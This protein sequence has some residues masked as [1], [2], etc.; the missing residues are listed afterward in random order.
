[1]LRQAE[2]SQAH[3]QAATR[4]RPDQG[5]PEA[6]ARVAGPEFALQGLAVAAGAGTAAGQAARLHDRRLPDAQR[7]A[8]AS[9]IGR[10]QG[11]RH[12]QRVIACAQGAPG[13]EQPSQAQASGQVGLRRATALEPASDQTPFE[14]PAGG[15]SP[16]PREHRDA[17]EHAFDH[18]LEHVRI[19]ADAAADRAARRIEADAFTLGADVYFR[20]GTYSPGTAQGDRLIGHELTHV[21]QNDHGRVPGTASGAVEVSEPTDDLEKEAYA[22]EDSIAQRAA[23]FRSSRDATAADPAVHRAPVTSRSVIQRTCAACAAGDESEQRSPCRQC[24]AQALRAASG[25]TALRAR[26]T[27]RVQRWPSAEEVVGS[28]EGTLDDAGDAAAGA[29]QAAGETVE[30]ALDEAQVAVGEAATAVGETATAVGEAATAA[31]E[32]VYEAGGQAVDAVTQFG[33]W[34]ASEAGEAVR[35]LAQSL[36]GI[37]SITSAG[38]EITAPRVCPLDA[39]SYSF[40]MAPIEQEFMVPIVALPIG[41]LIAT[42]EVGLAGRLQPL[43]E[44]QAGPFCLE[45]IRIVIDPLG[46]TYG[47]SGGVSATVAASLGAM[48][49]GGLRGALG[50]HGVV[51]IGGVPVPIDIP[52]AGLEGGPAGLVRGI[53]AATLRVSEGLSISSGTISMSDSRQLDLGLAGDL[54][55]GAY[56]QLDILGA[57]VCRLHWQPLEWHG[58]IAGSLGISMGVA[59]VPGRP[60]AIL[61]TVSPPTFTGIPFDQIPLVLE[62]EGFS[63]DCPIKDRLCEV[64]DALHLLPSQNG[65]TWDWGGSYGPGPRLGGPLEVYQKMPGIPSSA[66]CRGAC[67]PDCDT[68]KTTPTHRHADPATGEVW[69]YTNF[70]D[71]NTNAGCRE[72]DAA[73]DWAAATH[74]ETGSGAIIMPWHMAANIE[75]TCNNLAGNCIAWIAGLPPYDGK[76]YFADA[77]ALVS[78]GAIPDAS[79]DCRADY[80]NAPDCTASHPDR[81]A[82]LAQWGLPKGLT[83]FRDCRIVQDWAAGSMIGCDGAPGNIWH[84]L[85]TDLGSGQDVT[86]SLYECICCSGDDTSSS[87]WREPQV[88]VEAGM[89]EELI[90]DLCERGLIPR[91]ICIPLEEDMIGR[92]GD[93]RRDLDLDPDED[94]QAHLRPDDAPILDSFRRMYN[95]LDSWNVFVRTNHPG[96]YPEFESRFHVEQNRERWINGPDGIKARTKRYKEEFRDLRNTDPERSRREY[97]EY[98]LGTIQ[99]EI[100]QCNRAIAAWYR[101]ETGSTESIEEIIE[102]VHAEGTELWR[103]AWRQAILQVNRVLAR[104]WPPA[105]TKLLVWVGQQRARFP[106]VDLSGPV[107]ELDYIGS[108]A[109]GY[110]GPPKQQIRFNPDDFDVDANLAAPPLAKYAVAIDRL[111][112]DRQRIFGRNTSIAPLTEFSDQ[113]HAELSAR[114]QGYNT[115]DPFDVAIEAAELPVQQRHRLA[116]ERLYELRDSLDDAAYRRM[117]DELGAGGYLNGDGTAVREDLTDT[118]FDEVQAIMDR[119]APPA[120]RTA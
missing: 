11:N 55:V 14:L 60:P 58:D 7:H 53:G 93:R 17:F 54:F 63:D 85:A 111:R 10:A 19:H 89:S 80:P 113:T 90:L 72:H 5:A 21:L 117:L 49:S 16:L 106:L 34:L 102:R 119:H 81:D 65:G 83:D 41:S 52:V 47:I 64:L 116:T 97:R 51:P 8:L 69:E 115:S 77:A 67:G 42:G 1:M 74:G 46:G 12:L 114:V 22:A 92:F 79:A 101:D 108:L 95:R 110:K 4:R 91:V 78:G 18:G 105:K 32:T 37:I 36:D 28:I 120:V 99:R 3:A 103:A 109:T 87:A 44:V 61:P 104:L 24:A 73:F 62:R 13:H 84:C 118:Q 26:T 59:I 48:V 70:Q 107:G 56:G 88:V 25:A 2:A 45:G 68:C 96:L 29:V 75:C 31:G 30:G 94:P 57:N 98:V 15:G 100:E 27:G 40:D 50:L 38:L 71:C 33:D 35:M 9:R 76:M 39:L 43:V 82:V 66:Q 6:A 23:R 112:P 86:V 20:A